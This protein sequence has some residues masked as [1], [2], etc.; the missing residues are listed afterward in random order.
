MKKLSLV[1]GAALALSAVPF[2]TTRFGCA[3]PMTVFRAP[4]PQHLA[5]AEARFPQHA[6]VVTQEVRRDSKG[7]PYVASVW[8]AKQKPYKR[9]ILNQEN[10]ARAVE[11]LRAEGL[12]VV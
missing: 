7:R 2:G 1:A 11:A 10:R 12:Q 3:T 8:R 5:V 6:G 9:K 4:C